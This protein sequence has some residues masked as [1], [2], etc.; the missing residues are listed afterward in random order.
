LFIDTD[1]QREGITNPPLFNAM[2][3]Q[4]AQAQ[5]QRT[6]QATEGD[7]VPGQLP[8]RPVEGSRLRHV[9]NF[10]SFLYTFDET[11]ELSLSSLLKSKLNKVHPVWAD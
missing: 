1:S 6:V 7:T 3:S 5:G 11:I 10:N 2:Q 4:P 8:T 9:Y